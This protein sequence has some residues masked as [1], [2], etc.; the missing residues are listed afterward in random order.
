MTDQKQKKEY[1]VK[2]REET[3]DKLEKYASQD[4]VKPDEIIQNMLDWYYIEGKDHEAYVDMIFDNVVAEVIKQDVISASF[5]QRKFA[6]D[7]IK[8]SR[9]L[10]QLEKMGYIEKKNDAKPQKVIRKKAIS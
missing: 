3:I 4:G 1:T 9:I 10:S 2:L 7:F 6:V 8:S 5:I